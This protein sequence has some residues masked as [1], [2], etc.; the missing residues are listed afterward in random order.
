MLRLFPE[1]QVTST[2]TAARGTGVLDAGS[3]A[4]RAGVI[5]TA[6]RVWG[7]VSVAGTGHHLS[8]WSLQLQVLWQF[9]EPLV[10]GAAAAPLAP[11]PPQGPVPPPS[12]VQMYRALRHSTVLCRGPFV[13]QWMSYQL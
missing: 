6:A 4:G 1:P 13:G 5:G 8:S 9:L 10:L 11:L 12:D 2:A 3:T 7:G